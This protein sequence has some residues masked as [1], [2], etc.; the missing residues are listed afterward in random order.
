MKL[1]SACV[2]QLTSQ[3]NARALFPKTPTL[4]FYPEVENDPGGMQLQVLKTRK[5]TV[6][7]L[8]IG[9]F[10]AVESILQCPRD[11]RLWY[12]NTL[13]ALVP[14]GGTY[15]FDVIEYVGRA[16][17]VSGRSE[18]EIVHALAVRNI[19][20][21]EREIGYLGRKFIVYLAL[22]HRKSRELLR[23]SLH[24][25]GGYI[26]HVDGTCEGDSPHLFC[27]LDGISQWVLDSVKLPSEKKQLLVPFFR[28]IEAQYGR[29]LAL[30]HDMGK[31]ILSAVEEVFPE[32]PDFICHFH[33][34]RDIGKDL[35]LQDNQHITE[36]LRKYDIRA[37]LRHKSRSLA[38]QLEQSTQMMAQFKAG[39]DSGNPT[40]L[41]S[42]CS[43]SLFTLIHWALDALGRSNGY[44]FPFD[45]PYLMFYQRLKQLHRLMG[46]VLEMDFTNQSKDK[47]IFNSV[48]H[49]LDE[50]INDEVL[51]RTV[52]NMTA[53]AQVFDKLRAALRIALPDGKKGLND[54]GDNTDMKSIEKNMHAFRDWL[55][56]NQHRQ[57]TYA[58]MI[59]QI[60]KYWDKLFADPFIVNTPGGA[61][62]IFP[63]RTNNMLEQFFRGEKRQARKK[64]GTASLSK[65]L[66]SILAETPLV[67][68]LENEEYSQIIL[69]GCATLAERFSQIDVK[70]V[71]EHLKEA[72]QNQERVSTEVKKMIGQANLP[73]KIAVLFSQISKTDANRHL[74]S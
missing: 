9:A 46:D 42:L 48:W 6:V 10:R 39:V 35:L 61:V 20:I 27:G 19:T 23:R 3:L 66:K 30:V 50:F 60:D 73:D 18:R 62:T 16:L 25:R 55:L 57:Q 21:S 31:G 47:R 68:N 14:K 51:S 59:E 72:H 33:F 69:N 32:L 26:L 24:K 11:Q 44:G 28:R 58:K 37:R 65:T 13:R 34:L 53:K 43:M 67:R 22:A 64:S 36:C 4:Y 74:R 49:L 2:S 71:R 41:E 54:N 38:N 8:D 56:S 63:Q 1:L 7:T 45:R 29:P 40:G 15:G 52:T 17:F 5:K 12:S 70:Q